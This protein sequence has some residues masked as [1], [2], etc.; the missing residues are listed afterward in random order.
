ME[1]QVKDEL[2]VCYQILYMQRFYESSTKRSTRGKN[3]PKSVGI[4]STPK[5]C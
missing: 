5:L 1:D 3:A 2:N 4:T